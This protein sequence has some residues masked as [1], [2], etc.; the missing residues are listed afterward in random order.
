MDAQIF[1]LFEIFRRAGHELYLVGGAVRDHL[2]G[3]PL[4]RLQ[5][6]DFATSAMPADSARILRAVQLQVFTV[7]SRF[8]TVGTIVAVGGLRREIQITTYRGEVYAN[9]SRKPRVT[10]GKDLESDLARRDF[11]INAMAMT[12]DRSLID[13]F[14]GV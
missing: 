4:E 1:H 7:G 9:G 12:A 2:L 5:D 11:S 14:G 13:P 3:A 8:G 6:L 10:F